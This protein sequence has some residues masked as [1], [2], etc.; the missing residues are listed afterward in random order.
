MEENIKVIVEEADEWVLRGSITASPAG[1]DMIRNKTKD[2][3]WNRIAKGHEGEHLAL[4]IISK[5]SFLSPAFH[6]YISVSKSPHPPFLP[7]ST[8]KA[9]WVQHKTVLVSSARQHPH[10]KEQK[11]QPKRI[12][13]SLSL[14]DFSVAIL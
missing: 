11:Q 10:R 8:T 2:V 6:N 4:F 14:L 1:G 3:G 9:I 7:C 5:G 12:L 13:N